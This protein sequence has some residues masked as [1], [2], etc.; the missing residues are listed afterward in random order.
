MPARVL[1]LPRQT[2]APSVPI[3]R[4]RIGGG[5]GERAA[6]EVLF[7]AWELARAAAPERPGGGSWVEG[8][9]GRLA[10][11]SGLL[12]GEVQRGWARL[13]ERALV[14]VERAADGRERLRVAPEVL[15]DLPALSELAGE[16]VR[17]RLQR[18]GTLAPAL[19]VLR[20]VARRAGAERSSPVRASVDE[21]A[22]DTLYGRTAVKQAL[23]QLE[24]A[25]LLQRTLA[26]RQMELT[27]TEAAFEPGAAPSPPPSVR[28]PGAPAAPGGAG[29]E[30][31]LVTP[32][33]VT[34]ELAP[35]SRL[36]VGAGATCEVEVD[37]QGRT[38]LRIS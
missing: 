11:L 33:G 16:A 1:P 27:L 31:V 37:E 12:A 26:G 2:L 13:E 7:A 32:G 21:L 28:A 8:A 17:A 19:A 30:T 14:E 15:C 34:V 3:A 23:A 24:R 6:V 35:G 9:A 25:G 4:A 10:T 29:A 22:G 38:V 18:E 36:R 20:E 5:S